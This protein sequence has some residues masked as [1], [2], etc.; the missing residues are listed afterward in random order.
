MYLPE[1]LRCLFIDATHGG[2]QDAT[3][4]ISMLVH[5]RIKA[6]FPTHRALYL[7]RR[8]AAYLTSA[9]SL[10]RDAEGRLFSSSRGI[11]VNPSNEHRRSAF[12]TYECGEEL[13]VPFDADRESAARW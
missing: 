11:Q 10:V 8:I 2:R 5:Q 12:D 1:R 4:T 7:I 6:A 9:D 3:A 13:V